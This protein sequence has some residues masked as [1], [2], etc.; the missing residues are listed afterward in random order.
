YYCLFGMKPVH[1]GL[2]EYVHKKDSAFSWKVKNIK[3]FPLGKLFHFQMTSQKWQNILWKHDL[4]LFMPKKADI[5]DKALILNTGGR[6]RGKFYFFAFALANRIGAPV[7]VL[8]QI[9]NQPLFGGKKEDSLIAE[10][11]VRYLKTGDES[12]PLLFPMVKSVVRAMDV[13]QTYSK[14][15]LENPIQSFIITGSSKRGWTS[16]L[17]AA[18]DSR[19]IALIPMVIDTL[20]MARQIE[21]QYRSY[22]K[23]S[24]KLHDY[25]ERGLLEILGKKEAKKLISLV[26]PYAYRRRIQVPKLILNGTNDPYWVVDSLNLYWKG[27]QG[28]KFL[29]YVPNAGHGLREKG[30]RG[31]SG[32]QRAYNALCA[33]TRNIFTQKP[34]PNISWKLK[35]S[36][37]ELSI[38]THSHP[39]PVGGRLWIAYSPKRDFRK[40]EWTSRKISLWDCLAEGKA[41]YP[42]SGYMAFYIELDFQTQGIPFHLSTQILV[43]SPQKEQ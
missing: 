7:A 15:N 20:N 2:L 38:T 13:L 40:A 3:Q 14:K 43:A 12:Y 4:L 36:K 19:I 31:F 23:P 30:K 6:P 41:E 32:F 34:M 33:F 26:D 29:L 17:T 24:R 11:F 27:L 10:T 39:K 25:K 16:W 18:A 28:E 21:L 37:K 42:Q 22:G 8:F 1:A 5:K 35:K 9:P